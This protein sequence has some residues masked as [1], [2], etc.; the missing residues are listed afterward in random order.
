VLKNIP[1]TGSSNV[2]YFLDSLQKIWLNST[3]L[4]FLGGGRGSLGFVTVVGQKGLFHSIVERGCCR[5]F[6]VCETK[7][8]LSVLLHCVVCHLSGNDS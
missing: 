1:Y 3:V 6:Y 7:V 2:I 8:L 4:F 5:C